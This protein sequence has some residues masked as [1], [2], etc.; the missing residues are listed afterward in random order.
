MT[1][2]L[3]HGKS[4]ADARKLDLRQAVSEFTSKYRRRPT[5]AVILVGNDKASQIYVD[6]KRKACTEVGIG[7]EAFLLTEDTSEETLLQH[8]HR[9]NH[10]PAVDGIL[11]QLPLPSHIS[12]EK[13]IEAI[14]PK[15]DVD[16]FH[17]Y[18]FGHLAQRHPLLRPCT[19]MGIIHLL[20]AYAI[21]IKGKYAVVVGASNIVGRPM[22]LEFLHAGA[23]VTVCHRFTQNLQPFVSQAEILVVA[24]GI[25]DLINPA[26][27]SAKQI[28]IDVGMHRLDSGKIRGDIN[29]EEV[30]KKVAWLTPV[31]GGVGPMTIVSLLEN[32]LLAAQIAMSH[33][34]E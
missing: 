32:T 4:I 20:Q 11:V 15:K 28:V 19:P 34:H 9:L 10:N 17:P 29:F 3:L 30:V 8:I 2:S 1:A 27:L 6:N 26:W 12:T 23:T 14:D 5:L 13:I 24:T 16:G 21:P 7:S 18:N 25:Q 22:A 31:P 33:S